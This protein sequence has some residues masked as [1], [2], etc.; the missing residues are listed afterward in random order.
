MAPKYVLVF[1]WFLWLVSW[2]AASGW[3]K[4]TIKA[5]TRANQVPY[6]LLQGVGF[7]MLFASL[8]RSDGVTSPFL[9]GLFAHR[10]E[11][12]SVAAWI[13]AALGG[14]GFAFAW[15]ARLHLGALWSSSVTRKEDHR[16]VDTGP[17]GIVRHPIYT[18]L[19]AAS[20][21]LAAVSGTLLGLVGLLVVIVGVFLK[22]RLE[23][24]FLSDELEAGVYA[25]YRARV[26]MLIPGLPV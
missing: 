25:A 6:R 22:A 10:W 8:G 26:P 5:P 24:R 9:A 2:L 23:E 21:A 4:A 12:P 17:Y 20:V 15:W 3:A 18:G 7:A 11:L 13:A 14:A 1:I 16:V 19:L